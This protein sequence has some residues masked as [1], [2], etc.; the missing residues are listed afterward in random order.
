MW[1]W[2]TGWAGKVCLPWRTSPKGSQQAGITPSASRQMGPDPSWKPP[3]TRWSLPPPTL[4]L[5]SQASP[6]RGPHRYRTSGTASWS[7]SAAVGSWSTPQSGT[8]RLAGYP[9]CLRTSSRGCCSLKRSLPGSPPPATLSRGASQRF[10]AS[11]APRRG[12]PPP[13]P[14]WPCTWL[15]CWSLDTTDPL[16][17]VKNVCV[18][19][20]RRSR[21][22]MILKNKTKRKLSA[23]RDR[24]N[25]TTPPIK[26][27]AD[28]WKVRKTPAKWVTCHRWIFALPVIPLRD[29]HRDPGEV[30]SAPGVGPVSWSWVSLMSL[31]SFAQ[32]RTS[33]LTQI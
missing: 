26:H 22:I 15:R 5:F 7:G 27:V 1:R 18:S 30:L 10:D 31:F 29:P 11:G 9:T 20:S 24:P 19:D 8:A 2:R 23:T 17:G 28:A 12:P 16:P 21:V 14:R 4:G 33:Q 13:G 6:R 3:H 32:E 25:V